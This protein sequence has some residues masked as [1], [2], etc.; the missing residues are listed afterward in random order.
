MRAAG[1]SHAAGASVVP[2]APTDGE[3]PSPMRWGPRWSPNEAP[4]QEA[5]SPM[6]WGPRWSQSEGG[7]LA[8]AVGATPPRWSQS[9]GG[10]LTHAAG[11]SVIPK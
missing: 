2:K 9:E 10:R 11:A 7:P 4:L 3:A 8:H 5:P 6:W 1:A